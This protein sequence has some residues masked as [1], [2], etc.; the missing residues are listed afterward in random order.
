MKNEWLIYVKFELLNLKYFGFS[1][2]PCYKITG[3]QSLKL[4]HLLMTY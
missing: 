2:L 1:C 3:Q 4:Y